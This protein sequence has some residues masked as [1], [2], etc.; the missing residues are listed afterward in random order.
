MIS[1]PERSAHFSNCSRAAA[2]K[3]SPAASS[4]RFPASEKRF[5]NFPTLAVFP[6]PFTP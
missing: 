5:A 4:V 1:A 6:A 3:V 2:R